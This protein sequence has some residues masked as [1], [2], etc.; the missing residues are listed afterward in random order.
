[1]AE[2]AEAKASFDPAS[3]PEVPS[4]A[5]KADLSDQAQS[6]SPDDESAGDDMAIEIA[7]LLLPQGDSGDN[8]DL[9]FEPVPAPEP[10]PK[11]AVAKD[12][13]QEA[14]QPQDDLPDE[15][16]QSGETLV[17]GTDETPQIAHPEPAAVE[18][19]KPKATE[20]SPFEDW[21][22]KSQHR[23]TGASSKFA[24]SGLDRPMARRKPASGEQPVVGEDADASEPGSRAQPLHRESEP[25]PD[26][27]PEPDVPTE[28]L[29]RCLTERWEDADT[30]SSERGQ[31]A[32]PRDKGTYRWPFRRLRATI[33]H[34]HAHADSETEPNALRR[35]RG[36]TRFGEKLE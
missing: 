15:V 16:D 7:R 31:P 21:R 1:L 24:A 19:T 6:F 20:A 13:T 12:D 29:P 11:A 8:D 5:E 27:E 22:A 3:W 34:D 28:P 26:P 18:I 33:D 35:P 14:P 30:A 17:L 32:Q 25:R 4:G 9:L 10:E 23:G 2:P 36:N